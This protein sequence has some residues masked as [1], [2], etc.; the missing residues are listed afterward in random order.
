MHEAV[1]RHP[2]YVMK[3]YTPTLTPTLT[4]TGI[5]IHV[6]AY[7]HKP[8][9]FLRYKHPHPQTQGYTYTC[10]YIHKLHTIFYANPLK[11]KVIISLVFKRTQITYLLNTYLRT[12]T[13][14]LHTHT[15]TIY[16][17]IHIPA[18]AIHLKVL[19]YQAF[20]Y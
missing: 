4:N 14:V 20:S 1:L 17:R 10:T 11:K 8:H 15:R 3:I 7:I 18:P 13:C 12:Y 2:C 9:P 16:L 19:V 5:C 6:C